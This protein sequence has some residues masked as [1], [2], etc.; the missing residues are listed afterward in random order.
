MQPTLV[1]H[2]G[3]PLKYPENTRCG[4][5]A[6]IDLGARWLETDIQISRDGQPMLY[7]DPSLLRISGIDRSLADFTAAEL[8]QFPASHPERFGDQFAKEPIAHLE[9]LV[10]LLVEHPQVQAFVELKPES[11]ARVG[12]VA[13]VDA[14]LSLIGRV[15]PQV[16]IISFDREAIEMAR[17]RAQLHPLR[18]GW[19]LPRW[20]DAIHAELVATCPE[21][22]FVSH[23]LRPRSADELWS[24][25]WTWA[26]Y[27]IDD[28]ETA[29]E[30]AAR[31]M[32]F[33]ETNA[34]GE[35]IG[36]AGN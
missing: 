11:L 31:G 32:S 22:V 25:S 17:A 28:V 18:I 36:V 26:V 3:Y 21:F 30:Q 14:V 29:R 12:H 1:A 5:Q 23:T 35:L 27:S 6:A 33:I 4:F 7:H 13:M 9:R 19:V 20:D 15:R 2:R 24:G 16:V 34:I 8:E 10:E